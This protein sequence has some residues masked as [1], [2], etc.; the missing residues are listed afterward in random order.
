MNDLAL[1]N[2]QTE[3]MAGGFWQLD[4]VDL[5]RSYV[6]RYFE[7]IRAV[8]QQRSPQ[9]ARSLAAQLYPS[10]VV[11]QEVLDRTTEFLSDVTLPPGLRRVVLE[12]AD[13]LRRAVAARAVG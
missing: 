8:W 11:E 2:H 7:E 4:Q 13:D 1:S 6:P 10:V 5:C 12:R 3:A 9:V